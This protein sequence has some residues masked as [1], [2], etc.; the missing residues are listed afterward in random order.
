MRVR[1]LN[2]N[3]EVGELFHSMADTFKEASAQNVYGTPVQSNG[4]TVIPVARIAFGFGGG[5]GSGHPDKGGNGA[6]EGGGAGGG[7]RIVASPVGVVEMTS[8]GTRFVPFGDNRKML[9][10]FGLGAFL[11]TMLAGRKMRKVVK[12]MKEEYHHGA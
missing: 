11:G 12:A 5:G 7:G 4:T 6:H 9:A 2:M 8:E 1:R 3:D 10:A